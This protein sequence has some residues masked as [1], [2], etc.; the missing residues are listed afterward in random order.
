MSFRYHNLCFNGSA[1]FVDRVF[2]IEVL[3]GGVIAAF[4]YGDWAAGG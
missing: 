1:V 2:E 3:I 4:V